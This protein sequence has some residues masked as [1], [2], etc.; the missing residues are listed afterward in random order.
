MGNPPSAAEQKIEYTPYIPEYPNTIF[1]KPCMLLSFNCLTASG[2]Q[3]EVL[4]CCECSNVVIN[5]LSPFWQSLGHVLG[6]KAYNEP[7]SQNPGCRV[8]AILRIPKMKGATMI[9]FSYP[10]GNLHFAPGL[11]LGNYGGHSHQLNPYTYKQDLQSFKLT[12]EI[13]ALSFGPS[14]PDMVPQLAILVLTSKAHALKNYKQKHTG[15]V[16]QTYFLEL[17]PT[18]YKE[19]YSYPLFTNQY[20]VTNHTEVMDLNRPLTQLPGNTSE[21][22]SRLTFSGLYFSFELSP[23]LISITRNSK[24]FLHLL[25]R[26]CAVVGGAWVVFGLLFSTLRSIFRLN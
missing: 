25:T 2:A 20:S 4:R 11:N 19:Y 17:V 16:R 8:T 9:A 12:H 21:T 5:L 23:M 1:C 14:Y 7:L 18:I 22:N 13:F 6:C 24:S 26:L 3:G 15:V 10:Q